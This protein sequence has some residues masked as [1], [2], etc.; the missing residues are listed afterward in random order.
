MLDIPALGFELSPW[1][2]YLSKFV[3]S[4]NSILAD[5]T[6]VDLSHFDAIWA[7][8]PCIRRSSARTQGE[9]ICKE[10]SNDYL[11]WCLKLPHNP[12]WVENVVIQGKQGNDWGTKF[13]LA[14]FQDPPIQNRNRIIGGKYIQPKVLR[15]YKK[16]FPNICRM[17]YGFRI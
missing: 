12:L 1:K 11:E 10:F 16:T 14:Q 15:E 3:G 9:P 2:H 6:T 5:A 4:G 17:C 8:P 7:S 13:N